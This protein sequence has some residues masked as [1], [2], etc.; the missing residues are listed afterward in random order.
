[1]HDWETVCQPPR[2]PSRLKNSFKPN[3]KVRLSKKHPFLLP[4]GHSNCTGSH[5]YRKVFSHFQYPP[6][7]RFTFYK[8][9]S[10]IQF[11]LR[12]CE[13]YHKNLQFANLNETCTIL[14]SFNGRISIKDDFGCA[15]EKPTTVMS[16]LHA[17]S[18]CF[19]KLTGEM[20]DLIEGASS[21][22]LLICI[23]WESKRSDCTG[24]GRPG[25]R[26]R[27]AQTGL[28]ELT[29]STAPSAQLDLVMWFSFGKIDPQEG[30]WKSN[31]SQV[32]VR[33][34]HNPAMAPKSW[35]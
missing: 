14:M 32:P 31:T 29:Q 15:N 34:K 4:Q 10:A 9:N 25:W 21:K 6:P 3:S 5:F 24:T 20:D 18:S 16:Q 33:I 30:E 7:P 8:L 27:L 17:M 35:G 13:K 19:V 12:S 2:R 22:D 28:T 26:E 1:M 11:R 23:I